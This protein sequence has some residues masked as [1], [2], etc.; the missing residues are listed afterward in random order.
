MQ[1]LKNNFHFWLVFLIPLPFKLLQY[2]FKFRILG[3]ETYGF[4]VLLDEKHE[5]KWREESRTLYK[6]WSNILHT[7]TSLPTQ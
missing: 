4:S 1:R 5:N 2:L 7:S 6:Y 3:D